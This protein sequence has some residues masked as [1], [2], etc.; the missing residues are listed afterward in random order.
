MSDAEM[1]RSIDLIIRTLAVGRELPMPEGIDD[2][3]IPYVVRLAD[4]PFVFRGFIEGSPR[5]IAIGLPEKISCC[6]DANTC[7]LRFAWSGDFLDAKPTWSE[8]GAL[9][10]LVLGPKFFVATNA[11]PLRIGTAESPHVRF[12]GYRWR[13]NTPELLYEIDGVSVSESF[14]AQQQP[15][16]LVRKFRVESTTQAIRFRPS[17]GEALNAQR[18]PSDGWIE[19]AR[20][21]P[22]EFSTVIPVTRLSSTR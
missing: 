8:R 1:E 18:K 13:A 17:R 14:A 6:F 7:R 3:A 20:R 5:A 19:I 2:S 15:L 11:L 21:G 16:A 4:E 22:V 10:P 12:R 9:S